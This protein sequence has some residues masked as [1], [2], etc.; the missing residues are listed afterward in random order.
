MLLSKA[1][2]SAAVLGEQDKE[3]SSEWLVNTYPWS[4]FTDYSQE[5][6]WSW[7]P[8]SSKFRKTANVSFNRVHSFS[9]SSNN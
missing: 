7:S 5:C 4:I 9:L 3:S 2:L 1:I 6:P 8:D